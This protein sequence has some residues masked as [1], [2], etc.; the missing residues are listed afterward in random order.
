MTAPDL[1]PRAVRP[2]GSA[3]IEL[4]DSHCHVEMLDG[5]EGALAAA[6]TAGVG[7]V[8]SVG[9][10]VATSRQAVALA[11]RYDA[12]TLEAGAR[13]ERN[14]LAAGPGLAVVA[15]VGLHPHDAHCCDDACLA[16]LEALARRPGVVAVGECGLD[17]YR[18]LS[19]RDAQRRVFVAQVELARRV[20]LPLVVHTRESGDETLEL[21]SRHAAGLTVIM[22][23]FSLPERVDE[24]N[25]RGYYASF[26]GNLTYKNAGDLRAAAVRV[27]E[28][29]LMVETDAPFLT[30]V[31]YRG[32]PNSPARVALTAAVLAEARGTSLAHVAAVTT[33]NARRAF[34]LPTPSPAA[35]SPAAPSAA[36]S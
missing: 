6:A 34:G 20:G 36:G 19:P 10:D 30:P 26:A 7:V 15:T 22:H 31:P 4:I 23:C 33:A 3:P 1:T 12:A 32:K 8:V 11:E 17:F 35:P 24:C 2:H 5:V 29:L 9:I 27:R 13:T 16:D 18:D 28:D 14:G 21:L 25:A